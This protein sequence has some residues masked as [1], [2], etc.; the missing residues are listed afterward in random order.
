MGHRAVS[1]AC[2]LFPG[3]LAW[4]WYSF[5]VDRGELGLVAMQAPGEAELAGNLWSG[6][7]WN[8]ND[9]GPMGTACLLCTLRGWWRE[10]V[11]PVPSLP[12]GS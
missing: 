2:T 10:S 4:V 6:F 7:Q 11:K 5:C 12:V 9:P 3:H 1:V 8:P